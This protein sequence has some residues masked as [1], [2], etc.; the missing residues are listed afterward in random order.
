MS[1]SSQSKKSCVIVNKPHF[2]NF[3]PSQDDIDKIEKQINQKRPTEFRPP[4]NPV[5]RPLES[6]HPD[7]DP[8]SYP[9]A[10]LRVIEMCLYG[11]R[12]PPIKPKDVDIFTR[13]EN[14]KKK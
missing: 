14:L 11:R 4:P 6:P 1:E 12:D 9:D 7:P 10:S 13:Q 8:L 3:M 5:C 2:N